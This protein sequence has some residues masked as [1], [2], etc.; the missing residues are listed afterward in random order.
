MSAQE[1]YELAGWVV[2]GVFFLIAYT[3]VVGFGLAYLSGLR[4]KL[5]NNR[6]LLAHEVQKERKRLRF[7]LVLILIP[8][9]QLIAVFCWV[10]Y[11]CCKAVWY[12]AGEVR[13]EISN[14]L[15]KR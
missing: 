7:S 9:I 4:I 11:N 13:I 3:V 15:N 1:Q 14:L 5:K 12:S 2:K 8:G 10:I 6:N